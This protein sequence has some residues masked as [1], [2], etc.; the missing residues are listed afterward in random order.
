MKRVPYAFHNAHRRASALA[1]ELLHKSLLAHIQ[2][3]GIE[4][5]QTLRT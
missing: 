4:Y 3:E 2:A 1:P 5:P